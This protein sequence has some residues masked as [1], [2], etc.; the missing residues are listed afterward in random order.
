MCSPAGPRTAG[1]ARTPVRQ[2]GMPMRL[3][4]CYRHFQLLG[5]GA[6]AQSAAAEHPRTSPAWPATNA[7]RQCLQPAHRARQPRSA[8]RI[9]G[10]LLH[11]R[12][13]PP[14]GHA[15]SGSGPMCERRRVPGLLLSLWLLVP[16]ALLVYISYHALFLLLQAWQRLQEAVGLREGSTSSGSRGGTTTGRQPRTAKQAALDFYEYYNTKQISRIVEELIADDCVYEVSGGQGH[17]QDRLRTRA[18]QLC[19]AL[20]CCI[21]S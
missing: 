4:A 18:A 8:A 17:V 20:C 21:S 6:E 3:C 7:T 13:A 10:P 9:A 11:H 1:A 5:A 15:A 12:G 14:L 2:P 16:G 19:D